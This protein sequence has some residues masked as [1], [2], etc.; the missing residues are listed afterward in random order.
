MNLDLR[1]PIGGMFSIVGVMLTVYGLIS[2]KAIYEKSLAST[3][4]FWWDWCCWRSAS[5][6]SGSRCGPEGQ[7]GVNADAA[8]STLPV[9]SKRASE[10]PPR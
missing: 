9:E 2:D 10:P 6:C 5:R 1:L 8:G 4:N 3:V 7:R